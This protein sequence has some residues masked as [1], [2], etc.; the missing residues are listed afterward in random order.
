MCAHVTARHLVVCG[1]VLASLVLFASPANATTP[2]RGTGSYGILS[3]HSPTTAV[4]IIGGNGSS[5]LTDALYQCQY[6]GTPCPVDLT[7]PDPNLNATLSG[8]GSCLG[9]SSAVDS[10]GNPLSGAAP[11]FDLLVTINPGT[12]FTPGS[13]LSIT[14]PGF[15]D[16]NDQFGLL[17]CDS[18]SLQGF[19][20]FCTSA[21][22]AG[23]AAAIAAQSPGSGA[24]VNIPTACLAAGATF[25]FD[26]TSNNSVTSAFVGGPVTSAPEPNS[27]LL[28]G[29]GLASLAVFSK[30]LQRA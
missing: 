23:C 30:R 17:A 18:A 6:D 5:F 21:V 27:F 10:G 8:S 28:L 24:T 22:P 3:Q 13:T 19:T 15:S 4:P 26:E 7:N 25:Y 14:I 9:T 1:L 2:V 20:G 16:P 12:T 29:I 11:C